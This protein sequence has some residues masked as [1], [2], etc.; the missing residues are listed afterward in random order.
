L[1]QHRRAHSVGALADRGLAAFASARSCL[2]VGAGAET[3]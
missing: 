2:I 1:A 3:A